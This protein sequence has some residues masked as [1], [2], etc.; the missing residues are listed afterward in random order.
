MASS[1]RPP[2]LTFGGSRRFSCTLRLAKM[3]RSSGQKAT[4]RRATL[5][6]G[7][8]MV[9]T[10]ENLIEPSRRPTM[11]I[12]DLSVVVLPAPL[13]PSSVTTSPSRTSKSMPCRMCDSP[14]QALRP[15]TSR[16]LGMSRPEVRLHHA[17]IPGYRVVVA[18]G[19]DLTPLQHRDGV[20]KVR[21]HRQVVL[22]HQHR[23]VRRD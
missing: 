6:A 1:G 20:G 21:D 14:Y 2:S 9:S 4:P 12:T 3:P 7:K 18:F 23:A 15:L 8:R 5:S 16:R 10:P 17:R 13:R 19:E 22:D 11:P